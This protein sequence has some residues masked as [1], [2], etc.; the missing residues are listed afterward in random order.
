MKLYRCIFTPKSTLN[1]IPDAQTLFGAFCSIIDQKYGQD[2]LN[3]YLE[4]LNADPWFVHSSM[5]PENLFPSPSENL[6]P[7]ELV[8]EKVQDQSPAQKLSVLSNFKKYKR[9]QFI[10]D[11]IFKTYVLKNDMER[12]KQE[13]LS[14]ADLFRIDETSRILSLK[15]EKITYVGSRILQTRNG[16]QMDSLDKDLFYNVQLFVPQSQKFNLFIKTDHIQEIIPILK[17]LEYTGLGARR[18]VGMNQFHYEGC[19]EIQV[20]PSYERVCLLSKC[21][22]DSEDFDFEK[23]DYKIDS[24]IFRGSKTYVYGDYIGR[25]TRLLEGSLCQPKAVKEYYGKVVREVVDGKPIYHYGL[26]FVM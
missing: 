17:L 14:E 10:S 16:Q 8:N 2:K 22:P 5:F 19:E 9:L 26:G 12:L 20:D 11:P 15:D 6:F 25:F 13:I 24:R 1:Q 3:T 21:I 23:S 4:T 18:S 7:I